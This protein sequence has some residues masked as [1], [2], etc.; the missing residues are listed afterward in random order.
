MARDTSE[1]HHA[2][3]SRC[4]WKTGLLRKLKKVPRFV[5]NRFGY[6]GALALLALMSGLVAAQT[7]DPVETI[8]V[9]SDLVALKVSVVSLNPKNRLDELQQ[10]DFVVLEDGQR[11]DI[12]FFA[13]ADAPFDL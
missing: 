5:C 7:T 3:F 6:F 10:K 1:R 4:T 2:T 8:R 11:Q 12:S 9:D 13:A